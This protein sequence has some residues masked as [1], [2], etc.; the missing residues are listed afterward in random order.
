MDVEDSPVSIAD[1]LLGTVDKIYKDSYKEKMDEGVDEKRAKRYAKQQ[2]LLKIDEFF[3]NLLKRS[4]DEED[5]EDEYEDGMQ[6]YLFNNGKMN[7]LKKAIKKEKSKTNYD[8]EVVE[9]L[10][11]SLNDVAT[12]KIYK[13]VYKKKT[14][15]IGMLG[16]KKT[17]KSNRRR[18]RS[19]KNKK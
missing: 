18:G 15:S 9:I 17:R 13:S 1:N 7:T 10:L 11:H 8:V 5:N 2:A 19:K 12:N 14:V 4:R 6:D 3:R 16:G